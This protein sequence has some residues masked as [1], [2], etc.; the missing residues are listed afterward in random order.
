MFP[1]RLQHQCLRQ[2]PSAV[3]VYVTA[4]LVSILLQPDAVVVVLTRAVDERG[5]EMD[6]T[7]AG[8]W[9]RYVV[10]AHVSSLGQQTCGR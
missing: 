3:R 1:F 7:I 10:C 9:R 5:E 2:Q 6:R 4:D 8:L